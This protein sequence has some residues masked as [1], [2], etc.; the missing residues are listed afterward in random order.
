VIFTL[1]GCYEVLIGSYL[2]MFWDNLSVLPSRVKHLME[3][4]SWPKMSITN[5]ISML[6]YVP[7]KQRSH[8][9]RKPEIMS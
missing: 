1:L 4:V 9:K 8:Q 5:Y 2:L 7:E 6:H 3:L